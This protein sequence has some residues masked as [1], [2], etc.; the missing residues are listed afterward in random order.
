MKKQIVS[1]VG[2]CLISLLFLNS[3]FAQKQ[4]SKMLPSVTITASSLP[5][6][7]MNSFSSSYTDATNVRWLQIENR[8]LVKFNQRDMKHHA[9]YS[10]RGYQ[11]YHIGYG[12][13]KNLPNDIKQMVRSAYQ[14]FS[15]N[16][17]FDVT[18]NDRQMWLVNL[19][20]S[21]YVITA[22]IEN[23]QIDEISRLKNH[24]VMTGNLTSMV[25]KN[26]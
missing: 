5:D 22:K 11:V 14:D 26:R 20:N 9:L 6:R 24:S 8:Y 10:K 3:A 25:K 15:Y 17:V 18:Q 19:L 1:V 16:T 12:F 7:V 4:K 13:E 2:L 21:K 23:G